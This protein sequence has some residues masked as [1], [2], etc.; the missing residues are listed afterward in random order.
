M[1]ELPEVETIR[2]GLAKRILHK[3]IRRVEIRHSKVVKN[4]PKEFARALEGNLFVKIDRRGKLLIVHLRSVQRGEK[5]IFLLIHLKMTGQLIYRSGKT[6]VAGGHPWPP[7]ESELPHKHTHVIIT[8][9]DGSK[10]FFN[11]LRKFGVLKIVDEATKDLILT[12]YG[13]EPLSRGFTWER[14]QKALGRRRTSLKAVLLNQ[15]LI[16]GLGNIY[17][18]EAAFAARLRPARRVASLTKAELRRLFLV[19]PKVLREA[20]AYGGTTFNH[21]RDSDGEKGNYTDRLRVYG[22]AGK[23]CLRCGGILVKTVVAQRGTVYCPNCQR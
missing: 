18:D 13:V 19:I 21:F 5:R 14:F 1:P 16:A 23:K 7:L 15:A 3:K 4:N 6:F 10:I 20:I 12:A 2:R 9:A 22:R 11:D 17:V 8:F